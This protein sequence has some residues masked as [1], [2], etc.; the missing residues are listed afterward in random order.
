MMRHRCT[1]LALLLV[2]LLTPGPL[3]AQTTL[4]AA[5]KGYS[6]Q[7]CT[8][9][10]ADLLRPDKWFFKHELSKGMHCYFITKE[11]IENGGNFQTGLSLNVITDLTH[12]ARAVPSE[13]ARR[14]IKAAAARM[15]EEKRWEEESGELKTLHLLA[16]E[17]DAKDPL[18]M[19]F[20]LVANDKTGTL[21]LF[22][23]ESPA[24]LW[25]TNGPLGETILKNLRVNPAL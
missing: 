12:R 9:I 8:E 19:H 4:P 20:T 24:R 22:W 21:H 13:Y 2:A 10:S 6:W 3:A 7:P 11:S 23:Y 5:P 16:V 1:H 18:R 14:Y 25:E 15:T 17:K